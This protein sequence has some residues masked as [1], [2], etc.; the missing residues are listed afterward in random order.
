MTSP[1]IL[2]APRRQPGLHYQLTETHRVEVKAGV[3]QPQEKV[4]F[5]VTRG[6]FKSDI[7]SEGYQTSHAR[8]I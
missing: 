8:R 4:K 7:I 1:Y 3:K 2:A 6:S 5:V